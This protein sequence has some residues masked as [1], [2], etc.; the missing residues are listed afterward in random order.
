MGSA[1]QTPKV[2]TSAGPVFVRRRQVKAASIRSGCRRGQLRSQAEQ[3]FHI[4]S[5]SHNSRAA[6]PASPILDAQIRMGLL[7]RMMKQNRGNNLR[8][9]AAFQAAAPE[10][11]EAVSWATVG[12]VGDRRMSSP[13]KTMLRTQHP[14]LWHIAILVS[15][16]ER[17]LQ[18]GD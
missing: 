8:S 11:E 9:A 5:K 4:R 10:T 12:R 15:A 6:N 17:C 3:R 7:E 13:G 1:H 18:K 14:V 2:P 16:E